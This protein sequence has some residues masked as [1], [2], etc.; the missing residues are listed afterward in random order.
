MCNLFS[1]VFESSLVKYEHL[2]KSFK[3]IFIV[4]CAKVYARIDAEE[5]RTLSATSVI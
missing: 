1:Y 5:K 2:R 3:V 4:E